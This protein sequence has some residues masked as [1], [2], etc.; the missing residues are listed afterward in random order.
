MNKIFSTIA[1]VVLIVATSFAQE[2]YGARI[3]YSY[4]DPTG[5]GSDEVD[6]GY[7]IGAGVVAILPISDVLA[8]RSGVEINYNKLFGVSENLGNGVK[9]EAY[10]NE[11][12]ITVPVMAEYN[13]GDA[14]LGAGVQLGL[15]FRSE[16]HTEISGA[17]A[18][19]GTETEKA[20]GRATFD[21]GLAIGG[22]YNITP[23]IGIDVRVVIGL[24]DISNSD[25]ASINQY[26][27]GLYYMF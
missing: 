6:G 14:W 8:I 26:G 9:I 16:I 1:A 24:T 23:N 10:V 5:D 3:G 21:L 19:D 11:F 25:G 17:G 12:L 13:L 18:L 22:G 2:K 20:N 15:P 4:N 7:A 27:G